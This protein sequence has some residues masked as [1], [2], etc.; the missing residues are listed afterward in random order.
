MKIGDYRTRKC[1][2]GKPRRRRIIVSKF[3][4]GW[5][6]W[7]TLGTMVGTR[8]ENLTMSLDCAELTTDKIRKFIKEVQKAHRPRK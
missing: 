7:V 6:G 1:S 3:E 4:R 2:P 5:E 8:V